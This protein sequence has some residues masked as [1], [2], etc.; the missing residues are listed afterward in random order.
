MGNPPWTQTPWTDHSHRVVIEGKDQAI[1][2]TAT[3]AGADIVGLYTDA[4]VAARTLSKDLGVQRV[5]LPTM[6]L[7]KRG[8]WHDPVSPT[9]RRQHDCGFHYKPPIPGYRTASRD[10]A[11]RDRHWLVNM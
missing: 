9:P 8:T 5:I 4:S 11:D 2:D 3:I 7:H 6:S 1:R 10:E